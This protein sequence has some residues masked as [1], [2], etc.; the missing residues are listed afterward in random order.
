M[1]GDEI[2]AIGLF[3][4]LSTLDEH[5]AFHLATEAVGIFFYQMKKSPS[6]KPSIPLVKS[7]YSI[8]KKHHLKVQSQKMPLLQSPS[9][10]TWDHVN[11][12]PWTQFLKL[13]SD[14][15]AM[16]FIWTQVLHI[17]ETDIASA[18]YVSE[19]TIRFRVGCALR[20]I[21]EHL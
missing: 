13:A 8:W 12:E 4:F 20:K 17:S 6:T 1:F 15:E 11:L 10:W 9:W 14:D 3:F 2:K 21:S 19:G 16:S 18:T 7:C 5:R